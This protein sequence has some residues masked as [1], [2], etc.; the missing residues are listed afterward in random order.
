MLLARV[1][2]L[3][4]WAGTLIHHGLPSAVKNSCPHASI[5]GLELT[6]LRAVIVETGKLGRMALA[7][8]L[9]R[10][11]RLRA[12]ALGLRVHSCEA[13]NQRQYSAESAWQRLI[14]AKTMRQQSLPTNGSRPALSYRNFLGCFQAVTS[15]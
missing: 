6:C 4:A 14:S 12:D 9:A 11:E 1:S 2:I 8:D 13:A 15:F 3:A 5:S 7:V 10:V